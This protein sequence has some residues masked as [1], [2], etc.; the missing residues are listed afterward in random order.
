M[1]G[2]VWL[3][4]LAHRAKK[5]CWSHSH[6]YTDTLSIKSNIHTAKP[7]LNMTPKAQMIKSNI[8]SDS[9]LWTKWK[10]RMPNA[11]PEHWECFVLKCVGWW[12]LLHSLQRCSCHIHFW[13]GRIQ[14]QT[15]DLIIRS[16]GPRAFN[17][18]SVQALDILFSWRSDRYNNT[19]TITP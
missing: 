5:S 17:L 19:I 13:I 12:T 16:K 11:F 4:E 14:D 9:V 15:M 7:S 10:G 8:F 1:H 3:L 6:L 2:N 18:S